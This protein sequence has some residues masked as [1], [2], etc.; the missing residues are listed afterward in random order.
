MERV[1][2]LVMIVAEDLQSRGMSQG[3]GEPEE[4]VAVAPVPAGARGGSR[5]CGGSGGLR[6]VEK[7]EYIVAILRG[8]IYTQ[9][10][11]NT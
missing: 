3:A 7:I 2:T 1:A 5:A 8:A 10:I 11:V 4:A 6:H 9:Y